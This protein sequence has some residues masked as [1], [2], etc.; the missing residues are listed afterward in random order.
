MVT[1]ATDGVPEP[2][3][4]DSCHGRSRLE[5]VVFLACLVRASA[6]LGPWN[7][8]GVRPQLPSRLYTASPPTMTIKTRKPRTIRL[9]MAPSS[10]SLIPI[11]P[12]PSQRPSSTPEPLQ[13]VE[14]LEQILL[15]LPMRDLLLAQRV[16]TRWH[17]LVTQSKRIQRALYFLPAATPITGLRYPFNPLL[18]CAFADYFYFSPFMEPI[19][20]AS[21]YLDIILKSTS[22]QWDESITRKEASWRKML[23]CQP[24]ATNVAVV[25]ERIAPDYEDC[26]EEWANNEKGVTMGEVLL[27]QEAAP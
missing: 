4:A 1:D 23:V 11:A 20:I 9:K 8:H 2:I 10:L 19:Y 15:H 3:V 22:K 5:R 6:A 7:F 27:L 16:C 25:D 14:L 12:I 26:F 13:I 24:P 21:G 18:A 17:S